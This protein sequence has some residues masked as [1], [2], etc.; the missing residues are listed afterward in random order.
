MIKK[1]S[2][3]LKTIPSPVLRGLEAIF[4]IALVVLLPRACDDV[5]HKIEVANHAK[6]E[7]VHFKK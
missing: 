5:V 7:C 4:V 6:K 2:W 1:I 3:F